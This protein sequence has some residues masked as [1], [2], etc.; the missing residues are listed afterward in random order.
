MFTAFVQAAMTR[1]TNTRK[2]MMPIQ[3][4][5]GARFHVAMSRVNDRF[6]EPGVMPAAL[7]N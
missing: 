2:T 4:G 6:V 7:G 3:M 1:Y 5:P